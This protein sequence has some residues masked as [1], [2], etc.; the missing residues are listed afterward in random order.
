MGSTG[1]QKAATCSG[2]LAHWSQ[3][4]ESVGADLK[5]PEKLRCMGQCYTSTHVMSSIAQGHRIWRSMQTL[6]IH[7]V[8][9][10]DVF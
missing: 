5:E 8:A 7:L 10:S 2:E 1:E 9:A 4:G 6:S 3:K